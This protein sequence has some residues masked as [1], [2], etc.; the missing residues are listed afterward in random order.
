MCKI[1]NFIKN[2]RLDAVA[3]ATVV[4]LIMVIIAIIVWI[5]KMFGIMPPTID[6]SVIAD[7]VITAFGVITF[8]QSYWKNNSWTESAQVAD[9]IMKYKKEELKGA[10]WDERN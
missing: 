9:E 8:L 4:R 1:K 5:L 2:I 6:E 7:V 10:E 3:P